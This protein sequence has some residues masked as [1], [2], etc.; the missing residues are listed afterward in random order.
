MKALQCISSHLK[1]H[2]DGCFHTG[3][4][5]LSLTGRQSLW[6]WWWWMY[7]IESKWWWWLIFGNSLFEH[8]TGCTENQFTCSSGPCVEMEKRWVEMGR[9][10]ININEK[11]RINYQQKSSDAIKKLTVRTKVT[12]HLA[13]LFISILNSIWK[14]VS[15]F[16]RCHQRQYNLI[17]MYFVILTG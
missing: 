5:P 1:V 4:I 9:S 8:W 16:N 17:P 6:Y 2:G 12:K 15:H 7:K 10:T 3:P 14:R 13:R 11:W